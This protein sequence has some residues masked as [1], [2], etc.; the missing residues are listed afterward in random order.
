MPPRPTRFAA[1][2]LLG[3]AAL[4]ALAAFAALAVPLAAAQGPPP[5]GLR[6]LDGR[7]WTLPQV[8]ERLALTPQQVA[9]LDELFLAHQT[10]LI[11]LK[12]EVD[13]LHLR[14]GA[15][16]ADHRAPEAEIFAAIDSLEN[17]RAELAKSRARMMV[18]LREVLSIEQ[19]E[20]LEQ[21]RRRAA[22]RLRQEGRRPGRGGPAFPRNP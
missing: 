5:A 11:D 8:R 16:M 20:T 6:Q 18:R 9:R 7:F 21:L 17:A 22:R 1:A 12:S 3:L 13:K 2:P 10:R 14:F 19:R 4:A 15:L